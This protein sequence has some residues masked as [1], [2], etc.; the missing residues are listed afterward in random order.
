MLPLTAINQVLLNVGFWGDLIK[1]SKIVGHVYKLI[2]LQMEQAVSPLINVLLQE[3]APHWPYYLHGKQTGCWVE[4]PPT[5]KHFLC[6]Y[7]L[8][9]AAQWLTVWAVWHDNSVAND[10]KT[11]RQEQHWFA[12]DFPSPWSQREHVEV[13][14]RVARSSGDIYTTRPIPAMW[15]VQ[16]CKWWAPFTTGERHLLLQT[17]SQI[18]LASQKG[19]IW[20]I[21]RNSHRG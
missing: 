1:D 5:S 3:P 7:K 8:P 14:V 10:N 15:S 16:L 4:V 17:V 11:A 21:L 19:K 9:A 13:C 20:D 18:Y 6:G 12:R 2:Y